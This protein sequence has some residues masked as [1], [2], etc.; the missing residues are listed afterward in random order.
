M[1]KIYNIL[2]DSVVLSKLILWG[3]VQAQ[4]GGQEIS[5]MIQEAK[6]IVQSID[7]KELESLDLNLSPEKLEQIVKKGGVQEMIDN[8]ITRSKESQGEALESVKACRP[9]K[10]QSSMTYRGKILDQSTAQNSSF[11]KDHLIIFVS[12]SMPKESLRGLYGEAQKIGA[13]L[14]FRGLIGN[15]FKETQSYFRD[16]KIVADI[17]PTVFEENDIVQVPTFLVQDQKSGKKDTLKGHISLREALVK[18]KDHGELKDLSKN[19]LV[20]LEDKVA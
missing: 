17:D 16:L 8:S 13:R 15:S 20:N 11:R 9:Q 19:L 10:C 12:S 7:K 1:R 6:V 18:F 2:L 3:T 4:E 5:K 14:V